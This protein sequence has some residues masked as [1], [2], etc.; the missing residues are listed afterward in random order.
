MMGKDFK[1]LEEFKE[2]AKNLPDGEKLELMQN[3]I[4]KIKTLLKDQEK[5]RY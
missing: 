2:L 1:T 3:E 5:W 4:N